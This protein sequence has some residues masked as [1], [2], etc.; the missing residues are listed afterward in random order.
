V[1]IFEL[2]LQ[3][4]KTSQMIQQPVWGALGLLH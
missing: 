2:N 4:Y 3:R 1:L